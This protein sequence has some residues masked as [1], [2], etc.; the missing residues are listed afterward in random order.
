MPR[1]V[2]AHIQAHQEQAE[3]HRPP[4]AVEQGSIG[5]DA[6]AAFVQGLIAQLQRLQQLAVVLQDLVRGRLRHR[7]RSMGPLA[8]RP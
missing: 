7:Q 1:R 3:G 5:D 4:Q 2:L 8:G 6:H